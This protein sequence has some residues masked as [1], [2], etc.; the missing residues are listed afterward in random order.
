MDAHSLLHAS[1]NASFFMDFHMSGK[2]SCIKKL[3]M[4]GCTR[5]VAKERY[6]I[7]LAFT[8]KTGN[9]AIAKMWNDFG[10]MSFIILKTD[11]A[12]PM[13]AIDSTAMLVNK[14]GLRSS[15]F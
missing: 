11:L 4:D 7:Q 15:W 9:H 13:D 8:T 12:S 6:S 14:D 2:T 10:I 5:R 1:V 3:R